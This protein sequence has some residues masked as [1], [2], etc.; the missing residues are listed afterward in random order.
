MWN[1]TFTIW[2]LLLLLTSNILACVLY[3]KNQAGCPANI[4]LFK[5]GNKNTKEGCEIYSK[6]TIKTPEGHHWH[7][8]SICIGNFEQTPHFFLTF[9]LMN[10]KKKMLVIPANI[11]TLFQR[12]LEVVTWENVKSTLIQRCV[13]Q[14]W[15]LQR[16]TTS[17]KHMKWTTL[18]SVEAT[19]SF[20]TSS[21]LT[22]VN[23]VTTLWKWT[24]KKNKRKKKIKLHT[25]N[26]E[27]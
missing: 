19:L 16:G 20:S 11:S 15:N 6:L 4:H 27:F 17:N 1:S 18:N 9:L 5:V 3:I 23:V 13:F 25:L 12:S 14:R 10:L 8:S 21:F 7:R 26:S 22:L 24:S 2:L